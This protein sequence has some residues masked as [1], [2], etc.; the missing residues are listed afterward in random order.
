LQSIELFTCIVTRE[1]INRLVL[2]LLLLLLLPLLQACCQ[3][4]VAATAYPKSAPELVRARITAALAGTLLL[5]LLPASSL[6]LL[7]C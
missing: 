2:L 7:P 3:P 6:E 4:F 1:S 5:L